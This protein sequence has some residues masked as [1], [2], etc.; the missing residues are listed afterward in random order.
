MVLED[1]ERPRSTEQ[2]SAKFGIPAPLAEQYAFAAPFFAQ[3]RRVRN[4]VIHGGAGFRHIYETERGFCV[5]PTQSPFKDYEGWVPEHQFNEHISSVL[6]WI[7]D[8]IMKTIDVCNSL[9]G[10]FAQTIILPPPLAPEYLVYIR[11]PHNHALASLLDVYSGKTAWW[12]RDPES[13]QRF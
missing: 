9:I 13:A 7:A 3:L 10:R 11:G 4:G 1:K 6:P 5:N 8:I 2:I 12:N